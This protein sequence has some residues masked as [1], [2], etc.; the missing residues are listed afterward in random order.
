M[1]TNASPPTSATAQDGKWADIFF[2]GAV[3]I[4]C[5]GLKPLYAACICMTPTGLAGPGGWLL[6]RMAVWGIMVIPAVVYV[7]V[8][9]AVGA[10][11]LWTGAQS[12]SVFHALL[13]KTP[14]SPSGDARISLLN[15]S[16]CGA[17]GGIAAAAM[18][19]VIFAAWF[20]ICFVLM[21]FGPGLV[22]LLLP[23]ITL[24]GSLIAFGSWGAVIGA[25]IWV[26]RKFGWIAGIGA[27]A[28]TAAICNV[29]I[30]MI[31]K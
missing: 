29:I 19:S 3:G 23:I 16:K 30:G 15:A 18:I 24:I 21:F 13:A 27:G 8:V 31:V 4:L 5:G 9:A 26:R 1:Y 25:L 17:I 10:S 14:I 2:A 20:V 11:F 12:G 28:I 7:S 22:M 6:A